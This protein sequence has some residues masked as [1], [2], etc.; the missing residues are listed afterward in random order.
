M[1]PRIIKYGLLCWLLILG[2]T[3]ICQQALHLHSLNLEGISNTHVTCIYQDHQGFLWLGT[4]DGLNRFDGYEYLPFKDATGPANHSLSS[5]YITAIAEDAQQNLWIGTKYGLNRFDRATR[6]FTSYYAHEHDSLALPNNN[7]EVIFLD[8][9]GR[10][11]IGSWGG[12]S[13]YLPQKDAF[14]NYQKEA[15]NPNSLSGNIINKIIQDHKGRLWIGTNFSGVTVFS[16]EEGSFKRFF[17]NPVNH[18][19]LSGNSVISLFEDSYQNIWV[20]T[21]KNGLNRYEENS[22]SFVH[23]QY[24]GSMHSIA[25]NSIYSIMENMNRQLIV[26]GMQGGMSVYNRRS[27][28]FIRYNTQGQINHNGNTASVLCHYT[29]K[30][31]ENII[32][33]SNGTVNIYDNHPATFGLYQHHDKQN[34]SLSFNHVTALLEDKQGTLWIGTDGGGLNRFDPSSEQFTHFTKS[35]E[36]SQLK[37]NTILALASDPSQR[38]LLLGT[39][40]HG[41]AIFDRKNDTFRHYYPEADG[42]QQFAANTVHS[43][44][45]DAMQ[46]IWLGTEKGLYSLQDIRQPHFQTLATEA[47]IPQP[48][49]S[50]VKDS[51]GTLWIGTQEGL[52]FMDKYQKLQKF[53]FP[54]GQNPWITSLALEND[55]LWLSILGKGLFQLS[56]TSNTW[57]PNAILPNTLGTNISSLLKDHQGNWWIVSEKA[58]F[59]CKSLDTS[60]FLKIIRHYNQEDGLQ[61]KAFSPNAAITTHN[62]SI[63]LGGAL[64]MNR[65]HPDS[66]RTNPHQP[67]V[68]L[69]YFYQNDKEVHPGESPFL[70]L[71]ISQTDTLRL[72]WRQASFAIKFAALN[73]IKPSKNQYAY[74]LE[75][76]DTSW[77]MSHSNRMASYEQLS[78]GSY[79]FHVRASNHDGIWN[80]EGA[81][82]YILI[83]RP[84]WAA[85]EWYY[86]L[87]ILLFC[88]AIGY[89]WQIR[90][91]R[92]FLSS[93]QLQEA[94]APHYLSYVNRRID[95]V[96][97]EEK[98]ED[99]FLKKAVSL[100]EDHLCNE[101]FDIATMGK[102]LGTSR[103]QLY[104]KI[105]EQ[106]GKTVSE[107]IKEIKLKHACQLL[108]NTELSISE[109]AFQSGFKSLSHFSRTFQ[110]SY[111]VSPS[112]YA[113]QHQN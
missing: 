99:D 60:P 41:L 47:D 1:P 83:E 74:Q 45:L 105:K 6:T 96:Q 81:S 90:K 110:N 34:N 25:T 59:K 51:L 50:L 84:W 26:G 102:E 18:K 29:L 44:H 36:S 33:T 113:S 23:Y 42:S 108:E 57:S 106:T 98:P 30:S 64:G 79:R 4:V 43:I 24:D 56:I 28:T 52:Y 86:G 21:L 8:Q 17:S 111:G 35:T 5:N 10:L 95:T 13:Q 91:K 109:V 58:L 76:Y 104:R 82:V 69:T 67:P 62:G 7:I 39:L 66:L 40:L 48:I 73:F 101:D 77:Q 12:L 70:P 107:F 71:D 78:P 75:G 55:H 80:D 103:T 22:Q 85:S 37:D 2:G 94:Q 65:F 27:D 9:E 15:Q 19:S 53:R 49:T 11:W 100:V 68:S 14:R 88:I 46:Q 31:G 92:V 112:E 93:S 97:A 20:G 72:P 32:A 61:D 63:Y 16:P 38:Y 3:G 54:Q 87:A 89:L